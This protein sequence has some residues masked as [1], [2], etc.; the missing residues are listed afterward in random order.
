MTGKLCFT[1][2]ATVTPRSCNLTRRTD[3]QVPN[4]HLNHRSTARLLPT[5][6]SLSPSR[7]RPEDQPD[8]SSRRS[9]VATLNSV[10]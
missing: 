1:V 7:T 8:P 9:G 2:P 4:D 10:A 6:T 5:S 3:H